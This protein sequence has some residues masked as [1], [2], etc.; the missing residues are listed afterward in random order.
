MKSFRA[1]ITSLCALALV[2]GSPSSAGA[3]ELFGIHLFGDRAEADAEAVIADPHPYTVAFQ[4]GARGD[5][6]AAV[7][8]ASEL[9]G[10]QAEPASGAPGLLA[11]A[12]A[13]YR[14]IVAALYQEGYYG[15]TVSILVNG[16]EAANLPPDTALPKPTPVSVTVVPGPLF[17]FSALTITN[18]APFTNDQGD[19]VQAPENVG[20]GQGEP[21]RSGT[22]IKAE[23]LAV[24]AWRQLGYAKAK[25][26]QRQVVADHARSTVEV[27]ISIDPGRKAA[28]GAVAVEG[29]EQVDPDFIATQSG[30]TPGEEYDPDEVALAQKRLSRLEVFKALRLE[31][32]DAISETGLLPYTI[33]VQEM[34]QRRFGFGA[35][36]SSVDGFGVEGFWLHRNLFGRAERL[37]L[38]A[39]IAGIAFPL[40]TAEFDYAFGGTF[41]KPGIFTPDTDLVAT[42]SAERTVLPTYTETSA[43]ARVGLSHIFSDQL[44]VEAG[45]VTERARFDDK[46]GTRDF[47]TL[48]AYGTATYDA[49]NDKVDATQ[50]FYA[51]ATLDPFYEMTFGNPAIQATAELRGYFGFGDDD[52]FVLAGRVK[53]GGLLGPDLSEVPPDKLFFAG[54]GGSVRGYGFRSIGVD[55]GMGGVTGGRFLLEGS[56]EGRMKINESFGA[57]AFVDGGYVAAD[58]FPSLSELRIGAGVG[59]RYYTGF[60]P[61]R[62]DIAVPIN[63][64]PG[65]PN[66]ALYIGIGQAF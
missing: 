27:I 23:T 11:R 33:I 60:G 36:Y 34:A 25:V 56:V 45:L 37:R 62:A 51:R 38:D 6:D 53:A 19:V 14:R 9:L 28:F 32:A 18:R 13:D 55:D 17:R 10:N 31:Q 29:A 21:A 54:G 8:R 59:I 16:R 24:E 12:R 47:A 22:I 1:A 26:G 65:D 44:S 64:K 61:I 2:A 42:V 63:K 52:K 15:G 66:Y 57:V 49:R 41:T 46:F 48:G 35:T 40:N 3:F 43:L 58:T 5:L 4:S 50:G 30:L 39:K 20:F 7:R